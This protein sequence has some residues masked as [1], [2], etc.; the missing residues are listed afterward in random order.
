MSKAILTFSLVIFHA[1]QAQVPGL[2]E[3]TSPAAGEAVSGLVTI[4]GTADHPQFLSYDLSFSLDPDPTDT[5]FS[6]GEPVE[7]RVIDDRLGLWDTSG[8]SD[9]NYRMRLRVS[10]ANGGSIS[11]V[12]E[13]VRVRNY[14]PLETS[15]PEPIAAPVTSPTPLPATP[16]AEATEATSA[17]SGGSNPLWLGVYGGGGALLALGVYVRVRRILREQSARLKSRRAARRS[18]GG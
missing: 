9:G 4:H 6:I 16:T 15:E 2:V 10:F 13:G 17:P 12:V 5:W 7:A 18:R 1:M 3:I 14:T 8:L 11:T